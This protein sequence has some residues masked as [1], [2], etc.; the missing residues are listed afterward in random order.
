M[1]PREPL[2]FIE[3]RITRLRE[4]VGLRN[5][6]VHGYFTIQPERLVAILVEEVEPLRAELLALLERS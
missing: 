3:G 6:L 2:V 4:I 1:R 5:R